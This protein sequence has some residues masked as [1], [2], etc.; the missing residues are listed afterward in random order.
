MTVLT[1]SQFER[2]TAL[3]EYPDYLQNDIQDDSLLNVYANGEINYTI[4]GVHAKVSVVW[5]YEA[6][7]GAGDTHYSIMR[8]SKANLVIRQGADQNYKPTLYIEK[9]GNASTDEFAS[10]VQRAVQNLQDKYPEI[11]VEQATDQVFEV[12]V[13]ESYKNGHEA[14]FAQVAEKFMQYLKTGGLPA[15]EVPNMIAKYYVTTKGY[16]MTR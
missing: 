15:W 7:E 9:V 13:P 1:P 12:M 11:S 2:V 16:A 4:K 14:H 5:D 3:P 10:A 6:P 8:G